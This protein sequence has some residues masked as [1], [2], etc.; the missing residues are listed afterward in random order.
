MGAYS[1]SIRS[2]VKLLVLA[3]HIPLLKVFGQDRRLRDWIVH[4][5]AI[6][7]WFCSALGSSNGGPHFR[8]FFL[9]LLFF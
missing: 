3:V 8:Q 1:T 9:F 2:L 4:G 6:I 5:V 7:R